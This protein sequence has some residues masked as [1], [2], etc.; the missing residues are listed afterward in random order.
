M[1]S[2]KRAN[3][4][5]PEPGEEAGSLQ[6]AS[7]GAGLDPGGDSTGD[8]NLKAKILV[9]VYLETSKSS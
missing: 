9:F 2:V 7:D 3:S 5:G 8:E 4:D 1:C 6:Q